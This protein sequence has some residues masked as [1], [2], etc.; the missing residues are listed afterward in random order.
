M[1]WN[2]RDSL[3]EAEVDPRGQTI[4]AYANVLA[5]LPVL[6]VMNI[7][8]PNAVGQAKTIH[9]QNDQGVTVRDVL[10]AI[11]GF[12]W[13]RIR[14]NDPEW[15]S[16]SFSARRRVQRALKRNWG[17]GGYIRRLEFLG[18]ATT[19]VGLTKAD[20][21]TLCEKGTVNLW[22]AEFRNL[23]GDSDDDEPLWKRRP[24]WIPCFL[25]AKI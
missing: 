8:I 20:R 18:E 7:I 23:Y 3:S 14:P 1:H 10:H 15:M 21:H 22:V 4:A 24:R 12:L 25:R 5:T 2:V 9:V 19:F 17:S 11:E 6:K 13:T 16:L